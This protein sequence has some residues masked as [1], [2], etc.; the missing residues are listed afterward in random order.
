MGCKSRKLRY[1]VGAVFTSW[2]SRNVNPFNWGDEGGT[3]D[4]SH[5]HPLPQKWGGGGLVEYFGSGLAS[6]HPLIEPPLPTC[7]WSVAHGGLLPADERS[8][9]T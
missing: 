4:L 5:H 1:Y 8:Q 2:G 3:A 7:R 9:N 6:S